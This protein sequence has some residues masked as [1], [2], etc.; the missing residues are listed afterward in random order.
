LIGNFTFDQVVP[1]LEIDLA[2]DDVP[3]VSSAYGTALEH[4]P[5]DK[6]ALASIEQLNYDVI[7]ARSRSQSRPQLDLGGVLGYSGRARS[8]NGA[9][10]QIPEGDGYIWQ[11]DVVFN[12]PWGKR[13]GKARLK[14]AE[15][16]LQREE[17]RI[18]DIEQDLMK[19][20]RTAVRAVDTGL[21][22]VNIAQL[23]SR[24]STR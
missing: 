18:R 11:V 13:E 6:A 3:S 22:R 4:Q 24:L 10:D 14:Q 9:Y 19:E 20:I 21:E 17:L 2:V 15:L 5:E 16:V 8:F 12:V 1:K 7:L 23:R